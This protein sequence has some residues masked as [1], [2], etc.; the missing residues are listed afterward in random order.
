MSSLVL[1]GVLESLTDVRKFVLDAAA[2]AGLTSSRAYGL[3][4]AIDEIATNVIVH[5]YSEHGLSGNISIRRELTDDEL[6]LII[7]DTA[8]EFDAR[9]LAVPR[10]EDLE[11]PLEERAIGGLGVFLAFKN[12]DGFD[13]QRE[14]N[15]NR[16]IFKMNRQKK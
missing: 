14:G 16:N 6:S 10:K 8:V 4:L 1:P 11:K 7:E 12:I 15:V 2:E 13:Y 5:G 9:T 3:S